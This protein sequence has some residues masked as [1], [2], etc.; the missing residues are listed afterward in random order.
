MQVTLNIA[1]LADP[2]DA[3]S[4]DQLSESFAGASLGTA[5]DYQSF[6]SPATLTIT[7]SP[8]SSPATAGSEDVGA[9]IME[10]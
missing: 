6:L 5:G 1:N 3:F 8:N 2:G 10:P 9:E 4:T 7:I